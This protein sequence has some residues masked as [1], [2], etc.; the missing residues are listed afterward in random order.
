MQTLQEFPVMDL[1]KGI[2]FT[3]NEVAVI[4]NQ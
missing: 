3:K 4:G 1:T 2:F